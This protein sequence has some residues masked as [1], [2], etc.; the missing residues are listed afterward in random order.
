M[1][2]PAEI[3]AYEYAILHTAAVWA[4]L[5]PQPH[6]PPPY[7]RRWSLRMLKSLTT[8]LIEDGA[9]SELDVKPFRVRLSK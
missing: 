2:I 1:V 7:C 9:G 4:Y 6:P 8:S 5:P 3:R